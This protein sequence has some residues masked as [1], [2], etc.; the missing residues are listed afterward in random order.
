[1]ASS[2]GVWPP[3]RASGLQHGRLASSTG[4]RSGS[5]RASGPGV[6]LVRHNRLVS[7]PSTGIR[8]GSSRASGPG[9][10]LRGYAG[11]TFGVLFCD[12]GV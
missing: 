8:S 3:A 7:E 2:T 4:I 12:K 6:H 1:M 10:H 5:S 9:V 11:G